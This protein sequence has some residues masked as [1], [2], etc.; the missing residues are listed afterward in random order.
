MF[1]HHHSSLRGEEFYL[2]SSQDDGL[3]PVALKGLL[4][5]FHSR[6]H[7]VSAA[8]CLTPV[9]ICRLFHCSLSLFFSAALFNVVC[10]FFL[11][12]WVV[13]SVIC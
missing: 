9:R 5:P 6:E 7:L 8:F 3:F 13:H 11:C 12:A 2:Q 1:R 10:L 4:L